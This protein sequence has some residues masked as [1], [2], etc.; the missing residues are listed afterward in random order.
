MLIRNKTTD[1]REISVGE[2]SALV[3]PGETVEVPD[4]VANGTPAEGDHPGTSGLLAQEAVWEKAKAP[5]GSTT[6]DTPS[7]E[8]A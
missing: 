8:E 3:E 1:A 4:E 7:G 2:F 5:K 6:T